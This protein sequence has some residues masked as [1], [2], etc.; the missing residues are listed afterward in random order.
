MVQ[1]DPYYIQRCLDG[2]PDDYRFLVKKYQGILMAHLG[3]K[4]KSTCILEEAVQETFTR[5]YFNLSKLK[6][7]KS[8]FSWLLGIGNHVVLEYFRSQSQMKTIELDSSIADSTS[9]EQNNH[10]FELEY[11]I[12]QLKESYRKIVLLRYYGGYSCVEI[13]E[14]LKIPVNSVTKNLSRAYA[15]LRKTLQRQNNSSGV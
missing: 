14:Q 9:N 15:I 2:H 5:A 7:S 3:S 12:S 6:K 11:A 4:L 13:S 1:D 10:D 8:F